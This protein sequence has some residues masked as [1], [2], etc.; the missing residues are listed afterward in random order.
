[1]RHFSTIRI[2]SSFVLL[3]AVISALGCASTPSA[4]PSML[5]SGIAQEVRGPA[6]LFGTIEEAAVAALVYERANM[7]RSHEDRL[8]VGAIVRVDGGYR[9][10]EILG[11]P[12]D[13]ESMGNPRARIRFLPNHVASYIIH[14][15][16]GERAVDRIN[17]DL[18]SS[19][20]SLVDQRDPAHRP[21]FVLTPSGRVLSYMHQAG[22]VELAT[23]IRGRESNRSSASTSPTI[24]ASGAN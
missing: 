10:Q 1:M 13:R 23:V 24:L 19:E 9:W 15:R 7:M 5:V 6:V 21:I 12:L 2:A 4:G 3:A 18:N 20:R 17:E 22:E 11:A 14:P 16:T 8:H